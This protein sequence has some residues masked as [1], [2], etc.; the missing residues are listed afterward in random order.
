MKTRH[1]I[2]F[3]IEDLDLELVARIEAETV[4][5]V[6]HERIIADGIVIDLPGNIISPSL[7]DH[8]AE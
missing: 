8:G 4:Q 5:V 1:A 6:S 3:A 2:H 7:P